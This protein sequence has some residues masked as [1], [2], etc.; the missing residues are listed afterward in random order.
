MA[1][2]AHQT[3]LHGLLDGRKDGQAQVLLAGLAGVH[4]ADHLGAVLDRLLRVEGALRQARI[5]KSRS[6]NVH[7]GGASAVQKKNGAA[8]GAA[9]CVGVR[10][11]T[12]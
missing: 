4:A 10:K 11:T 12:R 9:V 7:G 3:Y 1:P 5:E 6:G 8:R 2:T